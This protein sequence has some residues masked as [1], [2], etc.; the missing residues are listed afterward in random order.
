M[1]KIAVATLVITVLFVSLLA[2][3]E[4]PVLALLDVTTIGTEESKGKIVYSYLLDQINK[5]GNYIIVE[6]GELDRALQ[7]IE[8]SRND[9]VDDS[10]A[11]E[12]GKLTGA[13]AVLISSWTKEEG[14][15]YLSLRIINIETA[16]VT[17]TSIKQTDSFDEVGQISKEAVDYLFGVEV[18]EKTEPDKGSQLAIEVEVP[19]KKRPGKGS[20]LA[21]ETGFGLTIPI[22]L[23]REVLGFGYSPLLA[24]SFNFDGA[25]GSFGF[26]LSTGLN[27]TST[28]SDAPASYWLFSI[29]AAFQLRYSTNPNSIFLFLI[30]ASVGAAISILSYGS[31]V[32]PLP[33]TSFL[34]ASTLGAGVNFTPSFGLY[35]FGSFSWIFFAENHYMGIAPGLG[36]VVNL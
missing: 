6:R 29:P 4:K 17:K 2:A 11:V 8:F 9:L 14:K 31:D 27:A 23:V 19:A 20:H 16:Q 35:V 3:Q 10:T 7:E 24:L 32:D 28:N 5:S 1:K 34:L 36:L 12:I 13:G 21:L 33:S 26:G 22:S 18:P 25:W 15:Y 30:N